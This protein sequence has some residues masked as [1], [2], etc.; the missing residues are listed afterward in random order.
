MFRALAN[1]TVMLC[2]VDNLARRRI[3]QH[4]YIPYTHGSRR[5]CDRLLAKRRPALGISSI[6]AL[7]RSIFAQAVPPLFTQSVNHDPLRKR[8]SDG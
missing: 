8:Q 2:G 7:T 6:T 4:A 1:H 3:E 5:I